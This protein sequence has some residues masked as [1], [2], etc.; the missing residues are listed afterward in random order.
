MAF[1]NLCEVQSAQADN[2]RLGLPCVITGRVLS[3]EPPYLWIEDE[4]RGTF[5]RLLITQFLV[6]KVG[7]NVRGLN[8]YKSKPARV[9]A[10]VW[11]ALGS[12]DPPI[13][14][15]F[16]IEPMDEFGLNSEDAIGY[17]RV[18]GETTR[19]ALS[20]RYP[21]LDIDSLPEILTQHSDLV[22]WTVLSNS[23][24]PIAQD[25]ENHT[26]QLFRLRSAQGSPWI[27]A[28]RPSRIF[29]GTRL[30][31]GYIA[32]KISQ[33]DRLWSC[34]LEL[35]KIFDYAGRLPASIA[36]LKRTLLA[37]GIQP[38]D[39][40]V[41]WLIGLSIL[42]RRKDGVLLTDRGTDASYL[43]TRAAVADTLRIALRTKNYLD[44]MNLE[45][46]T[47]FPPSLLL[48]GLK[49]LEKK[50]LVS[51]FTSNGY[52]TVLVWIPKFPQED[53]AARL[54]DARGWLRIACKQILSTLIQVP[55]PLG[56]LKL[57]EELNLKSPASFL[58]TTALLLYAEAVGLIE[59]TTGNGWAYPWKKRIIDYLGAQSQGTFSEE[60]IMA[61]IGLPPIERIKVDSALEELR[62]TGQAIE[63]LPGL[64]AAPLADT[65]AKESRMQRVLSSY[66]RR[67]IIQRLTSGRGFE[68][69][70]LVEAKDY[71]LSQFGDSATKSLDL[72]RICE[73][74][75]SAMLKS[76]EIERVGI[77]LKLKGQWN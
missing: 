25:F 20:A 59:N 39:D 18:R 19:A 12:R 44:L 30:E 10:V 1:E 71:L 52:E 48:R 34:L 75:V 23:T 60:E 29:D 37:R 2:R 35:V 66:C 9:L 57:A 76:G 5:A 77:L 62:N 56:T 13:A 70:T 53:E 31:M 16:W 42:V 68:R 28:A 40:A 38:I 55:Y 11:Y 61:K 45:Q 64:W 32:K 24:D 7:G 51:R 50:R 17:V 41:G 33:D 54:E 63:I 22:R 26:S 3:I 69:R 14:E 73:D 36:E 6:K 8:F 46:Q 65:V 72:R 47:Q 49:D 27:W 67:F 21:S 43:S 58:S 15:V 4:T 74:T